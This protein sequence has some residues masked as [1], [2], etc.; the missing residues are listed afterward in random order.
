M[1]LDFKI[2]KPAGVSPE[3]LEKVVN[4]IYDAI[5]N[6]ASATNAEVSRSKDSPTPAAKPTQTTKIIDDEDVKFAVKVDG[7]WYTTDA[8]TKEE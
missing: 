1:A 3:N 4:D 5:N 2:S 8:L 7:S 6:L